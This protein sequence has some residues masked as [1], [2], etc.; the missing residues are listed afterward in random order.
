MVYSIENKIAIML[1][2]ACFSSRS[3]LKR[4]LSDGVL[5]YES[6]SPAMPADIRDAS[7]CHH[8][9]P[10]LKEDQTGMS[11]STPEISTCDTDITYSR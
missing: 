7:N 6:S 8:P 4:S 2:E 11:E 5:I 3:F 1:N 10:D 9:L